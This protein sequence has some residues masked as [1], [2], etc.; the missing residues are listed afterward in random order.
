MV[1]DVSPVAD[2][3]E[4][5]NDFANGEKTQDLSRD[6]T[7]RYQLLPGDVPDPTENAVQGY[8]VC[9]IFSRAEENCRVTNDVYEGRKV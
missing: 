8:R 9:G 5:A 7:C 3:L 6:D 4:S 1:L 2:K